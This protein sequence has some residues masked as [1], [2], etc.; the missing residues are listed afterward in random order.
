MNFSAIF[1]NERKSINDSDNDSNNDNKNDSN[2]DSDY[3][4]TTRKEVTTRKRVTV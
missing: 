4:S 2:Y 3:Y 1:L